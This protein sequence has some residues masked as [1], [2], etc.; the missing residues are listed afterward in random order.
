MNCAVALRFGCI[1]TE[2]GLC[3]YCVVASVQLC[4]IESGACV[5]QNAKERCC[6]IDLV[7][8]GKAGNISTAEALTKTSK[9]VTVFFRVKFCIFTRFFTKQKLV[10]E[11]MNRLLL[12]WGIV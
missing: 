4:Q 1:Q 3:A 8:T 5:V 6:G 12:P 2:S 10:S 11:G 7:Q 9:Q